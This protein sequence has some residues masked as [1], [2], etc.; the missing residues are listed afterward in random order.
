[1]TLNPKPLGLLGFGA[2]GFADAGLRIPGSGFGF[3]WD[4]RSRPKS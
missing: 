4:T 1:M 3:F 2:L